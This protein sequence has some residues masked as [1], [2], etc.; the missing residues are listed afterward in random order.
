MHEDA[1]TKPYKFLFFLLVAT[2]PYNR[3]LQVVQVFPDVLQV[4]QPKFIMDDLKVTGRVH[5]PFH[6]DNLL[7]REGTCPHR[8]QRGTMTVQSNITIIII[9][10]LTEVKISKSINQVLSIPTFT[11]T[12]ITLDIDFCGHSL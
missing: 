4:F 2:S 3:A 11:K 10:T 1:Q 7:I 5:L 6:V 12:L 8:M 9:P